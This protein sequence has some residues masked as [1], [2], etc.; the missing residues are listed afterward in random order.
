MNSPEEIKRLLTP[1]MVAQH[2]LGQGKQR[3]NKIWYKSPWR[4]ERTASFMVDNK[5]FHDFGDSWDG[6][7]FDFVGRYYNTDFINAMKIISRDF[8]LPDDKPISKK[9]EQY[10]K[11]KREEELQMKINLNNWF[12]NTFYKLCNELH[13][14]QRII[15]YLK[16]DAL[17]IAYEKEMY[18]EY[19]IDEFI[20]A[21]DNEKI[22]L[23]KDRRNI[24]LWIDE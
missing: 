9:L 19:L 14:W 24:E 7:I 23:W 5:S 18:L 12:N 10:L 17:V 21:T 13:I 1:I 15:P 4:N 11:Q 2:Y 16:K 3:G 20:Y 6:D 8:G 22:E